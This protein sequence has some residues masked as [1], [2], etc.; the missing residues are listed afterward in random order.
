MGNIYYSILGV[1]FLIILFIW[2]NRIKTQNSFFKG[3][4]IKPLQLIFGLFFITWSCF[5]FLQ[6]PEFQVSKRYGHPI[7]NYANGLVS[8]LL[9]VVLS[10]G[11][12][13]KK[14]SNSKK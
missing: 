9:G 2:Y 1:A 7:H 11:A 3:L 12:I 13:K 10:W 6:E 5:T 14:N 4:E 8:L